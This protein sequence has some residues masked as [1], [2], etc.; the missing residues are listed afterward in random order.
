MRE[1]VKIFQAWINDGSNDLYVAT[2]RRGY[3]E[4]VNILLP[5]SWTDVQASPTTSYSYTVI[6]TYYDLLHQIELHNMEPSGQMNIVF[7]MAV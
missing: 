3:I 5:E 2:H 6:F 1:K 7:R 4:S